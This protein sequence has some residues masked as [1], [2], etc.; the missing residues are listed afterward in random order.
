MY[1][2][3]YLSN[4]KKSRLPH[5]LNCVVTQ[6]L[7]IIHHDDGRELLQHIL[8]VLAEEDERFFSNGDITLHKSFTLSQT[9]LSDRLFGLNLQ[10]HVG[11]ED[12]FGF[13]WKTANLL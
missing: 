13:L 6:V 7:I 3:S 2:C 8:G 12:S 5:G 9:R 1:G 10:N 4:A 11:F